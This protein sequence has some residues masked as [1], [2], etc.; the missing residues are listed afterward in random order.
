MNEKEAKSK[1]FLHFLHFRLTKLNIL[2]VIAQLIRM[3]YFIVSV[4]MS[5]V[6][7][8]FLR[9]NLI[10]YFVSICVIEKNYFSFYPLG[11]GFLFIVFQ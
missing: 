9:F 6:G 2:L 3:L 8:I 7:L 4:A 5:I 1:I 10:S 11:I